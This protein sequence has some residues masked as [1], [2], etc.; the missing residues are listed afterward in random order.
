MQ[1]CAIN[2]QH[3]LLLIRYLILKDLTLF[4]TCGIFHMNIFFFLVLGVLM[5]VFIFVV[6]CT[7][8]PITQTV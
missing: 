4:F 8:I 7:E 3:F 6:F 5:D 1:A 2:N